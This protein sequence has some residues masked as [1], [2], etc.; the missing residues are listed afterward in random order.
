MDY[1]KLTLELRDWLDD[2]HHHI[3]VKENSDEWDEWYRRFSREEIIDES[4]LCDN[5]ATFVEFANRDRL[6]LKYDVEV[7]DVPDRNHRDDPCEIIVPFHMVEVVNDRVDHDEDGHT[8]TLARLLQEL[9]ANALEDDDVQPQ[10]T[11]R[12]NATGFH[13]IDNDEDLLFLYL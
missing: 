6:V 11:V 8:M 10:V 3:M 12:F 7:W 1:S 2:D 9:E 5:Y 4:I 13:R